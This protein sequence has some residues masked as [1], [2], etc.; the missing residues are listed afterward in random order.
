MKRTVTKL[1]SEARERLALVEF[2]QQGNSVADAAEEWQIDLSTAYR[3]LRIYEEE[4]VKGLDIPRKPRP[5]HDLNGEQ[6]RSA[7]AG[8]PTKYHPRL[9]R[10]LEL[11]EGKQLKQVAIAWGVSAQAIM[12]DRRLFE[13]GK[14]PPI[15]QL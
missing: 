15:V 1:S 5:S 11:A 12:K 7:L 13:E 9:Q 2:I 10:L 14:L 6:I 3:W 4:G 8:A